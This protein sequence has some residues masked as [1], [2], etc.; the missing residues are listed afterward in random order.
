M[1]PIGGPINEVSL[2]YKHCLFWMVWRTQMKVSGFVKGVA[3]QGSVV[4]W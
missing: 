4:Y 3:W 1:D 2:Y